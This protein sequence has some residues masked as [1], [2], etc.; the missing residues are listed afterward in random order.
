MPMVAVKR[1]YGISAST[2]WRLIDEGQILAGIGKAF[3][4]NQCVLVSR[5]GVKRQLATFASKGKGVRG[6]PLPPDAVP[7]NE[8]C[9]ELNIKNDTVRAWC[10]WPIHPGLGRKLRSAIGEYT[11]TQSNG[12]PKR[13]RGLMV[14]RSDVTACVQ[15]V[16]SPTNRPIPGNPGEWIENGIFLHQDGG[17]LFFTEKYSSFHKF[18]NS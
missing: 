1:T 9:R 8:I 7:V 14:S 4:G 3:S 2:L 16:E 5:S 11:I 10:E 15:L 12:I 18:C 13:Y 17:Q 6:D